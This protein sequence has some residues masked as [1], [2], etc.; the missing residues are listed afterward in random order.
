MANPQDP[1]LQL[2]QDHR[3]AGRLD[4]CEALL[5]SHV[6]AHPDDARAL[7]ALGTLLIQRRRPA[8]GVP[9]LLRAAQR[10]PQWADVQ[11]AR[12]DALRM[13]GPPADAER[14][15]RQ[16]LAVRPQFPPAHN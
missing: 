15:Y 1:L 11:F 4:E 14:A 12:A 9:L 6:A 16:S 10:A 3:R 13:P 2:A 5:R 8:D 7:H